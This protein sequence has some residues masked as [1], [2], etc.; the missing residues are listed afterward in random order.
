[1]LSSHPIPWIFFEARWPYRLPHTQT[2][3]YV[4]K[5]RDGGGA[6]VNVVQVPRHDLRGEQTDPTAQTNKKAGILERHP[7]LH[8]HTELPIP[9]RNKQERKKPKCEINK[10][11]IEVEALDTI[12]RSESLFWTFTSFGSNSILYGFY[13]QKYFLNSCW[14]SDALQ[15]QIP[16]ICSKNYFSP[17]S[18][19]QQWP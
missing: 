19:K 10:R 16:I 9:M 17:A 5:Q 18:L 11:N 7:T 4:K 3:I 13:L 2:K 15:Q 8:G 14:Y 6:H 1:M 12:N